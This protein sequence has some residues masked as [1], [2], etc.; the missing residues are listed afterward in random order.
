MGVYLMESA[1]SENIWASLGAI[2]VFLGPKSVVWAGKYNIQKNLKSISCY[3][4][5]IDG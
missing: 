3:E 1:D 4:S 5:N 2:V